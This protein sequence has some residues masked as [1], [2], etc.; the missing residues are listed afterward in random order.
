MNFNER[1]DVFNLDAH[2]IS[3]GETSLQSFV[4]RRVEGALNLMPQ[5]SKI[6]RLCRQ[7]SL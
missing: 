5:Y 1:S 2:H 3:Q 7:E 6:K 4:R